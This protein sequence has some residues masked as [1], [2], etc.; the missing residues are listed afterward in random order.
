[1]LR[2][3]KNDLLCASG[4]DGEHGRTDDKSMSSSYKWVSAVCTASLTLASFPSTPRRKSIASTLPNTLDSATIARMMERNHTLQELITTEEYY[5]QD[6]RSLKNKYL[7]ILRDCVWVSSD[8]RQAMGRNV[9]EMLE[10]HGRLLADITRALP[11][12]TQMNQTHGINASPTIEDL[13][14]YPILSDPAAAAEVAKAFDTTIMAFFVYEE[15]S[16]K[17]HEVI[18]A[19]KRKE[20]KN[21]KKLSGKGMEALIGASNSWDNRGDYGK[22]AMELY[23]LLFKPI[24]R[25]CKYPLLFRD[26][27][28]NTPSI[29][30]PHTNRLLQKVRQRLDEAVH[31]VNFA[32]NDSPYVQ[33]RIKKTWRLQDRLHFNEKALPVRLLGHVLLCGTLHVTWQSNKGTQ[34]HTEYMA[35]ILFKSYLI[36]ASVSKS[37]HYKVKFAITL[38][39]ASVEESNHGKGLYS[40]GAPHTWKIVFEANQQ[41]YEVLCSACSDE[42]EQIWRRNI[43]DRILEESKDYEEYSSTS[44]EFCS[45][46]ASDIKPV[47][48]VYGRPGTL[49]RHQSL[50]RGANSSSLESDGQYVVINNFLFENDPRSPSG[51]SYSALNLNGLVPTVNL[52]RSDR[53]RI[54]SKLADVWTKESVPFNATRPK[55]SKENN[56]ATIMRRLSMMSILSG[57]SKKSSD[58][59]DS[60]PLDATW[61]EDYDYGEYGI[62]RSSTMF[63]KGKTSFRSAPPSPTKRSSSLSSRFSFNSSIKKEAGSDRSTP[64]SSKRRSIMPLLDNKW[65]TPEFTS[66][67]G[68]AHSLKT[69]TPPSSIQE[70]ELSVQA[71]LHD[72]YVNSLA[73]PGEISRRHTILT[74]PRPKWSSAKRA[75]FRSEPVTPTVRYL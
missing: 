44:M 6:L 71:A 11:C 42:E 23:D 60:E 55:P 70:E 68:V 25:L 12:I 13:A 35:C 75:K 27:E 66:G 48:G 38:A 67:C 15:Y 49:A 56:S 28:K 22:R 69:C 58:S 26:L 17:Y 37:D 29:D 62:H 46:I 2:K 72:N 51:G 57:K 36:L 20:K 8:V 32:N 9:T 64:P 40:P 53:N 33:E 1:M 5:L 73:V 39:V 50:L 24:Q 61:E 74:A 16:A 54:E 52:K 59:S 7:P 65:K 14:R 4:L 19:P 21:D 30:C 34:P 45:C 3:P 10:L 63:S 43:H 31:Q 41:I 47:G 18:N